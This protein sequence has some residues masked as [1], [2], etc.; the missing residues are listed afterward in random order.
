MNKYREQLEGTELFRIRRLRRFLMLILLLLAIGLSV[1]GMTLEGGSFSPLY[2]PVGPFLA[3]GFAFLLVASLANLVLRTLEI[4]NARRDSQRYLI[5]RNSQRR[6]TWV[7]ALALVVGIVLLVPWTHQAVNGAMRTREVDNVDGYAQIDYQFAPRDAFGL[8]RA[9]EIVVRV[10]GTGGDLFVTLWADGSLVDTQTASANQPFRFLIGTP[11]SPSSRYRVN[12]QNLNAQAIPFTIVVERTATPELA[13]IVPGVLVALAVVNATWYVYTRPLRRKYGASSI[14]STRFVE[15]TRVGEQTYADYYRMRAPTAVG[16]NAPAPM[17][18]S[19]RELPIEAVP[20]PAEGV[21]SSGEATA[22]QTVDTVTEGGNQMFAA[23][24]F[25]AALVRFEEA[26]GMEPGNVP[27]LVGRAAALSAL[28]RR[29]EALGA[30]DRAI[31]LDA[32]NA[33]AFSGKAETYE[34]DGQWA[35]AA[36]SWSD[37]LQVAAGDIDARLRRAELILKTGDRAAAVK[38]LEEALFLAPSDARIRARIQSLT[39][40]VPALL[41][42]AL[43]SSASGRTDEA[44]A[45]FEQILAADP[46]NVNALVGR[47]VAYRRAGELDRSLESFELALTKQP[48]NSAA[49]RAKGGIL[50]EKQ[51]FDGALHVYDDLLGL[52]SRDPEV[53]AL[54]GSVLERLGEPEEALASYHEALKL[55]PANADWRARAN[56]LESSRK[57]HEDFLEE[58]FGIKGLGPARVRA[59]LAAGYKTAESIRATTEDELANVK[60]ITRAIARDIRNH[61]QPGPPPPPPPQPPATAA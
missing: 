31:E 23:G 48:G 52:D 5:I 50:E 46:D 47:A 18:P 17:V 32:R 28:G 11:A 21:P 29:P 20:W 39:V 51:D 61:F 53:W 41:S 59:L 3:V 1:Y 36:Q 4:R 30:Y 43:V 38:A 8:A 14:Y 22:A 25:E 37:Y 57:G 34:A 35:N 24:K 58:L 42:R 56:A 26:L 15:E 7:I 60:G 27:A 45:D 13:T 9:S 44:I 12:V 10:Q 40:N 49:L 54:Q 19:A 55:D 33:K 16:P 2:L 6:A